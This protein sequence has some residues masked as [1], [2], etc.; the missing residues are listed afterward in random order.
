MGYT[1]MD[2]TRFDNVAPWMLPIIDS[3][4][5]AAWRRNADL[6]AAWV[7]HT[8]VVRVM[9]YGR[10]LSEAEM[11]SRTDG[12]RQITEYGRLTVDVLEAHFKAAKRE[13]IVG[14]LAYM[15]EQE[16]DGHEW[17]WCQMIA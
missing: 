8:M 2:Y 5:G 17:S 3:D 1:K 15:C 12:A 10:Y 7:M 4:P 16:S 11:A 14:P 9:A 6:L 13:H